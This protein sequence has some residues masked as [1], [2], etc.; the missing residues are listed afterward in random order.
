[1]EQVEFLWKRNQGTVI[2]LARETDACKPTE[3]FNTDHCSIKWIP[4]SLPEILEQTGKHA[5]QWARFIHQDVNSTRISS[6]LGIGKNNVCALLVFTFYSYPILLQTKFFLTPLS[7]SLF[8]NLERMTP[9]NKRKMALT[10]PL[11]RW[12]LFSD[13]KKKSLWRAML[14]A[15][16]SSVSFSLVCFPSSLLKTSHFSW[17]NSCSPLQAL[18]PIMNATKFWLYSFKAWGWPSL[19]ILFLII[20]F[21]YASIQYNKVNKV[22]LKLLLCK[23]QLSRPYLCVSITTPCCAFLNSTYRE[24][25]IFYYLHIFSWKNSQK[26]V[27]KFTFKD[28]DEV[29]RNFHFH[30]N[31]F[32]LINFF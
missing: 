15:S 9:F 12:M 4:S 8:S 16:C 20:P 26:T 5:C 22:A 29:E 10:S 3:C 30:L 2:I 14:C 13:L 11:Q 18:S 17:R 1:M 24:T 27:A 21:W 31:V 25:Q 19:Q 32:V 7:P 6:E 23:D 28:G